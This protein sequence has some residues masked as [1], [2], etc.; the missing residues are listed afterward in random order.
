MGQY[1]GAL[2]EER[3][4]L[5][6]TISFTKMKCNGGEIQ[7]SSLDSKE[8]VHQMGEVYLNSNFKKRS[9]DFSNLQAQCK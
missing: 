8:Q 6:K 7:A 1:L 2:G 4:Q 5:P 9:R 3:K